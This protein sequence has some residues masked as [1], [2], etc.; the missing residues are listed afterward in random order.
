MGV[1]RGEAPKRIRAAVELKAAAERL[2]FQVEY[3]NMKT[4]EFNGLV[5]AGLTLPQLLVQI[6]ASWD[7]EYPLTPD[8]FADLEDERPGCLMGLVQGWHSARLA[9]RSGN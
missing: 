7:A 2:H 5:E 1:R 6:V 3:V 8:G 9:E 4:S